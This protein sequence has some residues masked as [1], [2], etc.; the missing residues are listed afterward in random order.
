[1]APIRPIARRSPVPAIP[2]TSVENSS[3]AMIIL[4][5]RRKVSASGRMSAPNDG[6]SQPMTTPTI[7]PIMIRAVGPGPRH[8]AGAATGAP[9]ASSTGLPA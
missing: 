8:L 7:R 9:E 6:H 1:L 4:I 5:I 2:T 3:G